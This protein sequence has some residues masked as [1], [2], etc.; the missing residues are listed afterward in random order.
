M[1]DDVIDEALGSGTTGAAMTAIVYA[2]A[3]QKGGVAKTTTV[4]SLAAAL[5]ELGFAVLAV[6]LDP[7]SALTFS[8]GYDAAAL[9]PTMQDV[10]GRDPPIAPD[11]GLDRGQSFGPAT[12]HCGALLLPYRRGRAYLRCA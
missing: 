6:D 3:N 10:L 8:L 5:G 7:Q 2:V 1:G 12:V 9:S 4:I 11:L